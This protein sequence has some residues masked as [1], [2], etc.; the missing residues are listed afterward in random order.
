MAKINREKVKRL[1]QEEGS[2][3]NE[4]CITICEVLEK[5]SIIG[6]KNKEKIINDFIEN[7][8][9]SYEEANKLYNECMAI[10]VKER[11]LL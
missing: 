5:N 7:L 2:R 8:D 4:D 10:L 6:R 3:S 9:T 1:L 11:M